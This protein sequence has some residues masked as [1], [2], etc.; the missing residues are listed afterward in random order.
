M[1]RDDEQIERASHLLLTFANI[2]SPVFE[3][4]M[5]QI[6]SPRDAVWVGSRINAFGPRMQRV[7]LFLMRHT[8]WH[9]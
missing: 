5:E 3:K 7:W 2:K 1:T 6:R 9:P 8:P 4:A